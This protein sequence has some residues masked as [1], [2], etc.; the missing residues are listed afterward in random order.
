V[1]LGLANTLYTH[2]L[3]N[4]INM[5]LE[6]PLH[7]LYIT[8]PFDL[9]TMTI[10]FRQLVDR[11]NMELICRCNRILYI[12]M[13]E[14]KNEEKNVLKLLEIDETFLH[15]KAVGLP[16][17]QVLIQKKSFEIKSC[18]IESEQRNNVTILYRNDVV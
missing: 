13:Q 11:V 7:L 17:Q 4:L 12:Q 16:A 10:G 2:L 9:P 14:M 15:K 1:E 3:T 5:N 6:N 8:M 18:F